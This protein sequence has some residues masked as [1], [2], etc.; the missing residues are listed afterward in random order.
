MK[1]D[2][3]T[4]EGFTNLLNSIT[5]VALLVAA[6]L[7]GWDRPG[8]EP[9][10]DVTILERSLEVVEESVDGSFSATTYAIDGFATRDQ[11]D[12]AARILTEDVEPTPGPVTGFSV[13]FL[14]ALLNLLSQWFGKKT[15]PL[16]F[17]ALA[18]EKPSKP[19]TKS[20]YDHF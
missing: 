15:E 16:R 4:R 14:I 3:K 8:P 7:F 9:L 13:A 6:M 17:W 18:S 12:R 19:A 11:A 1:F 5:A 10:P 20:G 2:W